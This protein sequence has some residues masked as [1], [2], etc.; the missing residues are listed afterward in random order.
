MLVEE[1]KIGCTLAMLQCLDGDQRLAYILGELVELDHIEAAQV[2][3]ISPAAFRK[4]L[5][6]AR[7]AV[8]SFVD[9][10]CGLANPANACRCHRRVDTAI[11]LGRVDPQAPIFATSLGHARRFPKVL[12]EIRS[13]EAKRRAA[14][15]YRSHAQSGESEGFVIWLRQLIAGSPT[16]KT[17]GA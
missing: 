6:R 12:A 8:F 17:N 15:L 2:L 5:S 1:V 13:L 16:A 10:H 9:G 14:A 11:A 4:R 7:E 3:Q